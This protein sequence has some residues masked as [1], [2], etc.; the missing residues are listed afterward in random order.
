M[1]VITTTLRKPLTK[2]SQIDF[3][4]KIPNTKRLPNINLEG[5]PHQP[6]L[7]FLIELE[8]GVLVFVKG[9]GPENQEKNPRPKLRT[10]TNNK[11]NPHMTPGPGI[12]LSPLRHSCSPYILHILYIPNTST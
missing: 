8:F 11:L 9:G 1:D 10:K 3:S 6:W 2:Y 7:V 12:D 5:K 4:L